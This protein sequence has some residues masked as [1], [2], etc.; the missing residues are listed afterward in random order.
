MIRILTLLLSSVMTSLVGLSEIH[1]ENNTIPSCNVVEKSLSVETQ[2]NTHN[3]YN[4]IVL[5]DESFPTKFGQ[6]R[7][8]VFTK[9]IERQNFFTDN[10]NYK[11]IKARLTNVYYNKSNTPIGCG[12]IEALF[13]YNVVSGETK[14]LSVLSDK[15]MDENFKLEVSTQIYNNIDKMAQVYGEISSTSSYVNKDNHEYKINCDSSGKIS[16]ER[17]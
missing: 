17:K 9:T 13:R 6:L 2:D 7:R 8:E 16:Y 1:I 5:S 3:E 4:T 14:C 15:N 10:S 11:Y 12:Y